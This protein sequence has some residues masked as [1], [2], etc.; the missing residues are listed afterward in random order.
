MVADV[1]MG[2]PDAV[3]KATTTL[4]RVSPIKGR[5]GVATDIAEAA[6]WL[7]SD[8][9]GY[10]TGHTLTVDG[11]LTIGAG[12]P[13]PELFRVHSPMIRERGRRGL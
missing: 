2:D 4:A 11:G 12:N 9:S 5:P 10:V 8:E 7:A 1:M 13:T 3:E 6:V